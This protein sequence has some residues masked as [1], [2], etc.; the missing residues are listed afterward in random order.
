LNAERNKKYHVPNLERALAIIELL[1]K[2]QHGLSASDI[3][4]MLEIPANSVFRITMTLLNTG[5]L[6]RDNESKHFSLSR[7]FLAV[8]Y[9]ASGEISLIEIALD[10]MRE[11]REC[12]FE[13]VMLGSLL[14]NT[15]VVMESLPGLHSFSFT[16]RV[17]TR[18][19]LHS[20]AP[21]KAIIAFLPEN[22]REHIISCLNFQKFNERT[23]TE[24]KGFKKELEKVRKSG[25]AIDHAEEFENCHCISAPIINQAGYP[26]AA[27]WT[28]GPANRFPKKSF[29]NSSRE[30]IKAAEKISRKLGRKALETN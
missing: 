27:I 19:N 29:E 14:D 4:S 22:E 2:Y 30:I 7:K 20:S 10:I 16:A 25:F 23:I 13:T 1:A 9:A 12:I 11:L 17:G 15:G 21:G 8:G 6:N 28:S 18:F 24:K 3:A 5:Y 26:I